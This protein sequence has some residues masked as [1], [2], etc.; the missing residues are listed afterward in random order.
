MRNWVISDEG[1]KWYVKLHVRDLGRH[2]D[3]T[4]RQRASTLTGRVVTVRSRIMAVC[5]LPLD[6][7]RE[8]HILRTMFIS[9]ALH[10]VGASSFSQS[11]L[12]K[13]RSAFVA[14]VWS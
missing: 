2:F 7:L 14:A 13:L 10:G 5:A 4:Q 6:F 11:S 1:E 12:T 9:A 8:L 3:S